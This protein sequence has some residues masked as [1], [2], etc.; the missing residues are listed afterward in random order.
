MSEDEKKEEDSKESGKDKSDEGAGEK[1]EGKASEVV[2]PNVAFVSDES[3]IRSAVELMVE[4]EID[5]VLVYDTAHKVVGM[6]TNHDIVRKFT[7]LDMDDKLDKMVN[8]IMTRPVVFVSDANL[9]ADVTKLISEKK[10]HH[11]PVLKGKDPVAEKVSEVISITDVLE[12]LLGKKKSKAAAVEA[13]AE[14]EMK[15]MPIGLMGRVNDSLAG[16]SKSFAGLGYKVIPITNFDTFVR[17]HP[18]HD[19]AVLFD[20][21]GY[22]KNEMQDLLTKA[23]R[24]RGPLVL[25]GS[26]PTLVQGIRRFLDAEHQYMAMKPLDITYCHW[27]LTSKWKKAP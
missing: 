25:T 16:Y 24:Y 20:V 11:F 13:E 17:E 8:T 15:G 27:L 23:K 26:N 22:P 10:M 6:I 9:E 3:P 19:C 21:D 12:R 18:N 2:N 1:G 4:K 5:C 7:L 14:E